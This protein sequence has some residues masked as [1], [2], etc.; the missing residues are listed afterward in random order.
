MARRE[1]FVVVLTLTHLVKSVLTGHAPVTLQRTNAP[2]KKHKQIKGG[3]RIYH[4]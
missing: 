1:L 2:G 4:S 3:I